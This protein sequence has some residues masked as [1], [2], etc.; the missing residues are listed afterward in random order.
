MLAHRTKPFDG[1]T[2]DIMLSAC[3]DDVGEVYLAKRENGQWNFYYR[4]D[5]KVP[6]GYIRPRE[7]VGKEF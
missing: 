1:V 3:L 7:S 4:E 6:R 2:G 5:L